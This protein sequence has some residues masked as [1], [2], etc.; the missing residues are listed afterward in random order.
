MNNLPTGTVTFLFT[1]IEGSTRIAQEHP[2]DWE[3]LR[4]R[5]NTLIRTAIESFDGY[6]FQV[7]GDEFCAAFHT[8]PN[9][10]KAAVQAQQNLQ[11][12]KWQPVPVKVR[13]GINT[14]MAQLQDPSDARSDYIG[15]ATLARVSRV[16]SAGHGGQLL[17]SSASAELIR[18]ELPPDIILR[19]MGTQRL[20]GLLN[21]EHLWQVEAPNL[22]RDFPPLR[23]LSTI[24]NNLPAQLTSFI[25]REKEISAVKEELVSHRLVTLVGPGGTGKTRL[26]LQVAAEALG[27]YPQG[28]W[29]IE[30][31]ALSDPELVPQAILSA[32][33]VSEQK[34]KSALETLADYLRDKALLIL[35]DNCEHLIE[36]CAQTVQVILN[37]APNVKVL[38]SSRE[39]LGL[40]GEVSWRVPSLTLPNPKQLP[41]LDQLIQYESV[42][43]FIDRVLLISPRFAINKENAPAITQICFRLDGIP[44]A[45]ELAAARVKSMSVEQIMSRLDDRFRLLT[46]GSRTAL[47]RQQTLRA[48]IDWSYD[49]LTDA[50]KLLLRRLAVFTNGWTLELAEQICAD[51]KLHASDLL[52]TLAHLVDRSLAAVEEERGRM[53]YRILETVRQ[54]AREKLLESGEGAELRNRH[55]D[56]FLE[57]VENAAPELQKDTAKEW[58]RSLDAEQ[59]NIR[60][61]LWWS[62]ENKCASQAM[63]MCNALDYYWDFRQFMIEAANFCTETLSLVERDES[64]INTAGYALLLAEKNIY[65]TSGKLKL[66]TDPAT[67][68]S[69]RKSAEIFARLKFPPKSVRAYWYL[70]VLYERMNELELAEQVMQTSVNGSRAA[71]NEEDLAWSL[72]VLGFIYWRKGDKQ[73]SEALETEARDI[74]LKIGHR[75]NALQLTDNLAYKAGL[76]GNLR[77]EQAILQKSLRVYQD[78]EHDPAA[79]NTLGTLANVSYLLGDYDLAEKYYDEMEVYAKKSG[80]P[81]R[82][83]IDILQSRGEFAFVMGDLENALRYYESVMDLLQE[84]QMGE[85]FASDMQLYGYILLHA[86]RMEE[87]RRYLENS[88]LHMEKMGRESNTGRSWYGMGELERFTGNLP[89]ANKHYQRALFVNR[90]TQDFIIYPRYFD[91]FAKVALIQG[92]LPRSARWFGLA[93][94]MR[95]KF[96]MVLFPVDRSDYD[97]HIDLLKQKMTADEFQSA[98]AEGAQMDLQEAIALALQGFKP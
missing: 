97:K 5:C 21:T 87:A 31:A 2:A 12:E 24:P 79:A 41:E 53:R 72:F 76:L 84:N 73:Q 19:D 98:W 26:S 34:G 77:A 22:A 9:A 65:S 30:L 82:A 7:V 17:L 28:I 83:N 91:G 38:A 67:L 75:Q 54:Y 33:S 56:A 86:G 20:K 44:L 15:Y 92:D 49:L 40:S 14:G 1:D 11:S 6:V 47:P 85:Y 58:I 37:A 70:S 35:L 93:D 36:A 25:G 43:L 16:M 27:E 68:E 13:M 61:A 71:G 74:F 4:E 78:L 46:G 51:E 23:T 66:M 32:M 69:A 96:G 81:V 55:R 90:T 29:F 95:K 39:T 8:V 18:G 45:I 50:E 94:A 48:L 3:R 64:L 57:L 10:L 63:R 62:L 88:I 89:A 80:D 52:D 60:S 42:R 59:E